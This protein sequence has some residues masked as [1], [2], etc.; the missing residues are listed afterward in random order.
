MLAVLDNY[1]IIVCA[2]QW[3]MTWTVTM[4]GISENTQLEIFIANLLSKEQATNVKAPSTDMMELVDGTGPQ[5]LEGERL[6]SQFSLLCWPAARL[7]DK[8][9]ATDREQRNALVANDVRVWGE[10]V[11]YDIMPCSCPAAEGKRVVIVAPLLYERSNNLSRD[12][13]EL[14]ASF[15]A[16]PMWPAERTAQLLQEIAQVEEGVAA[17][18]AREHA[19]LV[20]VKAS[21]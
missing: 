11:P 8:L 1:E 2:P 9:V 17:T 14:E 19:N 20:N 5:E 3:K 10:G 15:V 13:A 12:F 7:V 18:A 16:G 6:V 4:S 21:A